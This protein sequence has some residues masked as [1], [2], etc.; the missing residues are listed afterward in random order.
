[1]KKNIFYAAMITLIIFSFIAW[2]NWMI[3]VG[4]SIFVG[5]VRYMEKSC[6]EDGTM[7]PV[8]AIALLLGNAF[9]ISLGIVFQWGSIAEAMIPKGPYHYVV[10]VGGFFVLWF[11]L[12]FFE[13]YLPALL[14]KI[15]DMQYD[16]R[17]RK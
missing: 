2:N 8:I 14:G 6:I 9:L 17:N 5:L 15:E 13:L 11:S 3:S 12:I 4:L 1:M 7:Y 10:L 16:Y